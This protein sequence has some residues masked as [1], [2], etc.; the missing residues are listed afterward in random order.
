FACRL[1]G[2]GNNPTASTQDCTSFTFL[3][4]YDLQLQCLLSGGKGRFQEMS[5]NKQHLCAH[6]RQF[7]QFLHMFI[8]ESDAT[9]G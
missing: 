8:I 7:K 5:L 6:F 4:R 2:K 1:A 3:T 9:I